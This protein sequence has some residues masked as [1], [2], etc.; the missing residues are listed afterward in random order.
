MPVDLPTK[1]I[2]TPLAF[3]YKADNVCGTGIS[4]PQEQC[5]S[6]NPFKDMH[7]N[8]LHRQYSMMQS[9]CQENNYYMWC[10]YKIRQLYIVPICGNGPYRNSG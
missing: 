10:C 8:Q 9:T 7:N 4:S 6:K 1:G 3:E 5:C 2:A